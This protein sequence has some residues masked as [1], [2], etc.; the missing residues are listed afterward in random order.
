MACILSVMQK[1]GRLHAG[2]TAQVNSCTVVDGCACIYS[3]VINGPK[4]KMHSHNKCPMVH[5]VSVWDVFNML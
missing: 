5:F 4:I 2:L 1:N 3:W